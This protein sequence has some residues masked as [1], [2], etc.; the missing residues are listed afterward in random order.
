M[1]PRIVIAGGGF[2]GLYAALYLA[3][4]PDRAPGTT[5]TLVD[6]KNFFTFTPLLAEVASGSL[7]REHVT[8]PY[9]VFTAKHDFDFLQASVASIDLESK[10]LHTD[11]GPVPYDYLVL[12]LGGEARY[13]GLEAIERSAMPYQT[14]RH[15][16]ALRNRVIGLVER[17]QHTADTSSQQAMMSFVVAGGGPAGTEVAS[18]L[19]H[20]LCEIAPRY[21]KIDVAPRIVLV[22]A[23][24]E[25]LAQ[26]D[27]ELAEAGR[28]VLERRGIEVCVGVRVT[29]YDGGEVCLS[30]GQ[31][32][33]ADTLIWTAGV[34]PSRVIRESGLPRAN[35]GGVEVDEHLRV[36]GHPEVYAV[37]DCNHIV[38]H[39]TGQPYPNVAPIAINQGVQ[40]AANIENAL[41]GRPLECYQAHYAGKIVSLGAGEALA[42]VLGLRLTGRPAW[43]L[44]R[45]TYLLKLVGARPKV[46]L[47]LTL[48]INRLLPPDLSYEGLAGERLPG[49]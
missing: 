14:L 4:S 27:S 24:D 20:L 10:T 36:R 32:V 47:A 5:I 28:R 48:A 43:W 42:D 15:A 37:G 13:F 30:D 38:N 35:G 6:R 29:G 1:G 44:Y 19:H 12:G 49:E 46:R 25:I 3:G 17:L 45:T 34:G 8:Q 21:Y 7:G 39:R 26:F 40:A 2:G 23:A 18:E 41:V 31:R 11:V 33:R 22:E 9:R 16:L